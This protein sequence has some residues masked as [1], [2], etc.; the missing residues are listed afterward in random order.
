MFSDTSLSRNCSNFLVN[1]RL[2]QTPVISPGGCSGSRVGRYIESATLGYSVKYFP[3]RDT[4]LL[5]PPRLFD[6]LKWRYVRFGHATRAFHRN[7]ARAIY[8]TI[9]LHLYHKRHFKHFAAFVT[10]VWVTP[11]TGVKQLGAML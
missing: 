7:I 11:V 1:C 10:P 4:C 5:A 6:F 8:E 9:T 2:L 3:R